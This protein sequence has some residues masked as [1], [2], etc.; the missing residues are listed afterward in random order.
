MML[1]LEQ[2]ISQRR[3]VHVFDRDDKTVAITNGE[4]PSSGYVNPDVII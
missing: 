3:I 2:A 4:K 1:K